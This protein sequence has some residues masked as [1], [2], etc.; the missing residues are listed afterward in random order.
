WIPGLVALALWRAYGG[1]IAAAELAT[2]LTGHLLRATLTCALAMT[3][4]SLTDNA[5]TAAVLTLAITL[6]TWA[7]DF[8]AQVRGGV[9]LVLDAYTPESALRTFE[10]G[11]IRLATILVTLVVTAGAVCI[12]IWWLHIGWTR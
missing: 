12:A 5:A 6:G 8:I 3:A 10:T 4:A 11:E 2:V 9:A 7:L 1:H